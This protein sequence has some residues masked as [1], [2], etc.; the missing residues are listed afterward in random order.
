MIKKT[1]PLLITAALVAGCQ[2]QATVPMAGAPQ[3]VVVPQQPVSVASW[4]ASSQ[5]PKMAD[6]PL[7]AEEL[8]YVL[9]KTGFEPAPDEVQAWVGRTRSALV[10]YLI[11]G[12][13]AEAV[14]PQPNWTRESVRYWG[15]GEWP[16]SRRA[17][18]RSARQQ[19]I[20]GLRQWWLGQM[21]A[22]PSPMGERMVMF[23]ENT[24]VAGFSGLD[25]KSHAQWYHHETIRR[26]ATGSYLDLL[27][28]MLRDPAVL[29]YLDN[30]NNRKDAPNENLAREL[31]ELYTLG[32]SNYTEKDIKESARA[33]AG[34]HVSEFGDLSFQANDWARDRSRK[35]IFGKRGNFNGD[36]MAELILAHPQASQHVSRRLWQEFVSSEAPPAEAIEAYADAFV[37]SG[38]RIDALLEV[39]LNSAYFWDPAYRATSVKSPAELVVGA[40]RASKQPTMSLQQIDS[41]LSA[42]GQ[43][44]FDPPDVSGW[45]YGE[46]WLD[47]AYL[48]EREVAMSSLS[49][50]EQMMEAPR[51]NSMANPNSLML[52]LAGEAYN[53]PPQYR[54][55]VV[56]D[57]GQRWSSKSRTLTAARDTER[58]G[59]Y[60]DESEWV[61]ENQSIEL[62]AEI[63]QLE[64]VGVRFLYDAAGNGG[65]RNLFV[66]GIEWQ[67]QYFPGTAG[68]QTPGCGSD[69]E[70]AK[71]HPDR[72][73]C[74]GTTQLDWQ[75]LTRLAMQQNQPPA[76]ITDA[77]LVTRELALLWFKPPSEGGWQGVDLMFDGLSFEGREWDY[78]GFKFAK[79]ERGHYMISVDEERCQ[80]ACFSKW[81]R[82]AWK[83]KSG[84]RHVAIFARNYEE[85]SRKQ[86]L[87]LSSEDKRLVKAL[88]STAP[89]VLEKIQQSPR[90]REPG[91]LETWSERLRFFANTAD[92][93]TWR[94]DT[95]VRLVELNAGQSANAMATAMMGS[96]GMGSGTSIYPLAGGKLNSKEDWLMLVAKQPALSQMPLEQWM[97]S[98]DD[99]ERFNDLSDWL[100][101][102]LINLK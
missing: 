43:T 75:A 39:M 15:H 61:W 72:L 36:D 16:E 67:G 13:S 99:G 19:E 58:L 50:G 4:L 48:I 78:F 97:V 68:V 87:Q 8:A 32:E 35:T 29:I 74:A 6:Q 31:L 2:Q 40:I 88:F 86:Y 60:K 45:G 1:L 85:W 42:M 90:H 28:A 70:G 62:P 5:M 23:W 79:D 59:R 18:F 80:P 101:S 92:S 82:D 53:G 84:L 24:F 11:S 93:S 102:P 96:M 94:P 37:A 100:R 57:G 34:W 21:L 46:Y 14:I 66:G 44:L 73:Y 22:T 52:K 12:L 56:H 49:Q 17:A 38:Y 89:A 77:D 10:K 95:P 7:S 51:V 71:R 3:S 83:D 76:D 65:D 9:R 98:I 27:A 41:A 25:E 63:K 26:H 69:R 91:S 47:P 55:E 30:N 64:T 20:G 54:V 33:L 81:P